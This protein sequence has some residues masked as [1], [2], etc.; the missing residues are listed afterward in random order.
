M[1]KARKGISLILFTAL[2]FSSFSFATSA[3]EFSPSRY[4]RQVYRHGSMNI[5]VAKLN[6]YIS[7][8]SSSNYLT[9]LRNTIYDWE[10]EDSGHV[11]MNETSQSNAQIRFYDTW[12]NA[13]FGSTAFAITLTWTASGTANVYG[14]NWMGPAYTKSCKIITRNEVYV[15]KTSQ[16][17]HNF[18]NYDIRKTWAHEIGHCLGF[19]ETNDG[20]RT[21][22]KQ[23][24]GSTFGWTNYWKPQD[25]DRSDLKSKFKYTTVFY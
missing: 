15:N 7:N 20:T 16:S 21:V 19:N 11:E 5:G 12:N 2:I 10:W 17:N 22:M 9:Q 18:N 1:K 23:G 6:Y 4:P 3:H 24:R 14:T 8:F 25:H 13:E